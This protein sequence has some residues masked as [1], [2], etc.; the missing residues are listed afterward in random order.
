[1]WGYELFVTLVPGGNCLPLPVAVGTAV[2]HIIARRHRLS[3]DLDRVLC[4]REQ[5]LML[6]MDKLSPKYQ[7]ERVSP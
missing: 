7:T 5:L 2:V 3:M 6:F 4:V 1:M